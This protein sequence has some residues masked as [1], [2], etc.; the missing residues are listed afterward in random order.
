MRLFRQ[1]CTEC[2]DLKAE[3]KIANEYYSAVVAY[4]VGAG[5]SLWVSN[6]NFSKRARRKRDTI[7]LVR[8]RLF[9]II[10]NTGTGRAGPL[11]FVAH[12]GNHLRE[13]DLNVRERRVGDVALAANQIILGIQVRIVRAKVVKANE[14]SKDSIDGSHV[15]APAADGS[16]VGDGESKRVIDSKSSGRDRVAPLTIFA[17]GGDNCDT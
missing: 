2:A 8:E 11:N 15:W 9:E 14:T 4:G 17:F 10:V 6:I 3:R 7:V 13:Y 5:G 12:V 1:T 16:G